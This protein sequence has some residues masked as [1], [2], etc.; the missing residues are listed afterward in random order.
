MNRRAPAHASDLIADTSQRPWGANNPVWRL[1]AYGPISILLPAPDV[2]SAYYIVV[3]VA[4][5]P[6]ENDNDRRL[7]QEAPARA[8]GMKA[9]TASR[10]DQQV[11]ISRCLPVASQ[12]NTT[13]VTSEAISLNFPHATIIS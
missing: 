13:L 6:S 9:M 4:D 12:N 1:F 8:K 5:D 10:A 2:N 11:R 7:S 3:M